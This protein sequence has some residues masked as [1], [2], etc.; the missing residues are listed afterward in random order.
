M[1]SRIG[2]TVVG[3]VAVAAVCAPAAWP[4]KPKLYSVAL[5]GDV[6]NEASRTTD[7]R[8]QTS[9]G[10]HR[11]DV[12]D[13]SVRRVGR[14]D[15]EAERRAGRVIRAAAVPG[16]LDIAD[17]RRDHHERR[18]LSSPTR[19][20]CPPIRARARSHR[21]RRA[22]PAASPLKRR[23]APAPSSRCFRTRASTSSTTTGAPDSSPA[24]TSSRWARRS[25][26][27]R[28]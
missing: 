1:S 18:E 15:T 13:A 26:Q 6:R 10:L 19:I 17:H 2:T 4:A 27:S 23:A 9:R 21:A 12:R 24:T 14:S 11:H 8:S 22:G 16:S 7:G 3:I 5:K 25:W 28:S 20:T